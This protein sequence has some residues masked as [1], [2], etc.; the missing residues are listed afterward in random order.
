M[1]GIIGYKGQRN[2]SE[3]VLN[4]LKALEYRGYDSWGIASLSS[5]LDVV[6]DIGKIGKWMIEDIDLSKS[7]LAIGHTRWATHGGVTTENAHPHY[8]LD[9]RF[10]IVQ[11]GIVENY[12]DLKKELVQKGYNFKSETDTEVIAYIIQEELKD[13]ELIEGFRSA[14]SRLK[15]RNA[16]V[17]IDSVSGKIIGA[18]NGSPLILGVGDGEYILASD[19]SPIVKYTKDVVFMQDNDVVVLNDS[20]HII[21][22][23]TGEEIDR[24]VSHV[25]WDI[26]QAQKGDYPH[27]MIKE[28]MEQRTTVA[29]SIAQEKDAVM[30]IANALNGAFGTY[31]VGCGTAAKVCL[32]AT[33]AFSSITH[34]HINFSLGSEFPSYHH[35]LTDKSLLLVVS[36]SGETADT[37]E[38][39]EVMKKRNGKVVSLVNVMGSSIMRQS[40]YALLNN[41]GPEKSVCSTKATTA[42]LA[43]CILLAYAAADKYDE[44]MNLLKDASNKLNLMLN[45]QFCNSIKKLACK[46]VDWESMYVLGRGLNYSI[47]LEASI[48]IQEVSYIHAEGFAGGELKH[49]PIA[50]IDKGTPCIVFVA[51]DDVKEEI[52]GNAMEVKARGGDIIGVSPEDN[53]IFDFW[54][55][56]PD[57]GDASPIVNIVPIQL[58]A[59]Y[60][61]VEKGC[62]VDMPRNLA[63]SVTVK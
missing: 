22:S 12:Q 6:K 3:V 9:K 57:V 26:K 53:S 7:S 58:L 42:Q 25:S 45:D 34:K 56:V 17:L 16:V 47:A 54:I 24:E 36:Q 2:A 11:N 55:K 30:E 21:N 29:D 8:S 1:C 10:A 48:K 46:I 38:A 18:R 37:L 49:G 28:I 43:Q 59:Y 52:L 20:Y 32:A 62:D 35:F 15:G 13:K 41:V 50:L 4:G 33:Y 27:F 5:E 23:V 39:I 63:K 44:G 61:A 19:A 40:D 31:A 51:N 14:F 60:L